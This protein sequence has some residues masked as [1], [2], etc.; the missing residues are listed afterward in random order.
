MTERVLDPAAAA[1]AGAPAP[2]PLHVLEPARRRFRLNLGEVW[3]FRELLVFLAWRDLKVRY[4]QTLFGAAWAVIQPLT[5]MVVFSLVF[6]R[7]AG[8][9]SEGVPYPVFTYAALLPWT[10]FAT[11][12]TRMSGSIV[13]SANLVSKI[14][15]PRV[16]IPLASQGAAC[17]DFLIAFGIL[18]LMMLGFGVPITWRILAVAPLAVL[19]LG[20]ASGIGLWL[21]AL[22]VR[23]R[24]VNYVVPFFVQIWMF[25]SPVAYSATI[26]ADEL[27]QWKWLYDL[28]PL[29]GVIEGFRWALLGTPWT[30][31]TL[32]ALSISVAGTLA[33]VVGSLA[34]FHR[35]EHAFADVV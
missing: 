7:L 1:G 31:G 20:A 16:L 8:L 9:P 35:T 34:Y 30:S 32:V 29:V 28:N 33:L 19:A 23:Y 21:A 24:D 22:N 11:V 2:R 6:G 14:Y 13:A 27:P 17:L 18:V 15:F 5:A 25:V 12:L 4:R 10:L 3:A 26:V